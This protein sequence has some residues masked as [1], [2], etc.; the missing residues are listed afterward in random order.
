MHP[1]IKWREI[2]VRWA[3]VPVS[4]EHQSMSEDAKVSKSSSLDPEERLDLLLSHLGTQWQ[5]LSEREAARRLEQHG[6][7]E[8]RRHKGT[9]R[10]R[11]FAR[12][13]THPLALLL[14]AAA[15]L[16]FVDGRPHSLSP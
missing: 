14:W 7:N 1:T 2:A 8:I 15:I 10:L 9:S 5:G 6:P 16:A 12:Q 3:E 13:F 11:E 4:R